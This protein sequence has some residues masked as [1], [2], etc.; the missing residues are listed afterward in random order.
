VKEAA[1]LV[2]G[3]GNEKRLVCYVFAERAGEIEVEELR[4]RLREKLPEYMVPGVFVV[5]EQMPLTVNGKLDKRA[6]PEPGHERPRLK[7]QFVPPRNEAEKTITEIW[8]EVLKLDSVGIEDNFFEIGGHSLLL[9]EVSGKLK[10][11]LGL[12]VP[13]VELF[14]NPTISALAQFLSHTQNGHLALGERAHQLEDHRAA[15]RRQREGRAAAR[16]EMLSTQ[17]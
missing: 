12:E 2:K 16:R 3:E 17:A 10:Q 7:Q 11:R 1:V 6:L 4:E 15:A 14:G 8:C 5:L 13:V 9:I